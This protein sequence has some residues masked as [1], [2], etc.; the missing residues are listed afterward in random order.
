MG[1]A[2]AVAPGC[3]PQNPNATGIEKP[4][5]TDDAP[6]TSEEAAAQSEP[7]PIQYKTRRPR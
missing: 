7:E 3:T 2:L 5:V 4:I 6:M 1:V